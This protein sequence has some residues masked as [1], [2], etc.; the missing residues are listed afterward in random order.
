MFQNLT[1][2]IIIL[3]VTIFLP[4]QNPIKGQ[5]TYK[6]K[7]HDIFDND[8]YFNTILTF[9]SIASLQTSHRYGMDTDNGTSVQSSGNSAAVVTSAYD[10]KGTLFYRNRITHEFVVRAK[11]MKPFAAHLVKENWINIEW[12]IKNS[13]K[14]LLGYKVQKA[15]GTFRGRTWT[16]WFAIDIPYPFG[17]CKLHGLPGVIL[18][19]SDERY[20][21]EATNICYPC[22][23]NKTEKIERPFEQQQYTIKQYVRMIDNMAVYSML[24]F[25]RQEKSWNPGRPMKCLYPSTEES[26]KKSRLRGTDIV[27]EWE[28]KNTKRAIYNKDTLNATVDYEAAAELKKRNIMPPPGIE[29]PIMKQ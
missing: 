23:P 21:Y 6:Q 14:T 10:D 1:D 8:I 22:D 19:A 4:N 18:Q 5:I 17:P 27:Y 11:E 12:K 16:A 2:L 26:I 28:N 24:E 20:S 15:V 7:S 25:Q 29:M 3:L 9:D 13:F